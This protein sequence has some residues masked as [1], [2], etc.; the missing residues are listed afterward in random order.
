MRCLWVACGRWVV[1]LT[2]GWFALTDCDS[3]QLVGLDLALTVGEALLRFSMQ[4]YAPGACFVEIWPFLPS[5]LVLAILIAALSCRSQHAVGS[6]NI[7]A[8]ASLDVLDPATDKSRRR[9]LHL[10]HWHAVGY[11]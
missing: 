6:M 11:T 5:S 9:P 3:V 2:V 10:C 8:L 7:A 1:A 4:V